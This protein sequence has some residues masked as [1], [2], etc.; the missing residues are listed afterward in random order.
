MRLQ[1]DTLK[2]LTEAKKR[3]P[4]SLALTDS[5]GSWTYRELDSYAR[6]CAVW[7]RRKGVEPGDRVV[8]TA[9]NTRVVVALI[10]GCAAAGATAVPL[11]P[12]MKDFHREHVVVDAQP[13]LVIEDTAPL[14]VQFEELLGLT[15]AS[16]LPGPGTEPALLLYTS[17]S[18]GMPKA[19]VCPHSS[20]DFASRAVHRELRYQQDDV[21]LCRIPLSFDYGLYQIYL[22]ALSGAKLVLSQ[23]GDEARI[24]ADIKKHGVTVV[25]LVPSLANVLTRLAR[26]G[27]ENSL[28]RCFTNTG[29]RLPRGVVEDLRSFF[30]GAEVRLMFG[31]TEC[32]RITIMEADGDLE[33]PDSVGRPL[34]GTEVEIVDFEG[35]PLPSG[36]VGEI[37]VRGPHVM[38]GYW[39]NAEST[40]EV[41]RGDPSGRTTLHTGDYGHMD[42]EG[43]VYFLGRRDNIFKRQ[44]NRV[45]TT[46]IETA[47]LAVPGVTQAITL[48]PQDGG[49][50]KLWFT[51]DTTP[52]KLL[53]GM[54]DRLEKTKVPDTA[55]RVSSFPLN[56][57]GKIDRLKVAAMETAPATDTAGLTA[58]FGSPLYIYDLDTLD[59]ALAS[60]RKTVPS[61]STVYYSLKANPHPEIVRVFREGGARAEI[62]SSG[63]LLSA[64]EAGFTGAEC[65]Y[66]GPG[67]TP[68]EIE[69][70]LVHGVRLFSV[71]S[72][73][74]YA[75]IA[76]CADAR[77]VT[78][79][80][81][82]RVNV[83]ASDSRASLR[84]TGTSTQFGVDE[85]QLFDA[86]EKFSR[87]LGA[88]V[89]G[90]HFFSLSN[91]QDEESLMTAMRASAEA[92]RRLRDEGGF[93]MEVVDLGGG[94]AAPYARPGELPAYTS[95]RSEL[96][97]VLDECLP[98]WRTGEVE[99]AFESG[100]YLSGSCGRLL[101]RVLDLKDS[102]GSSFVVTDSGIN[103]L[104]GLAGL[105]RTLPVVVV[106]DDPAPEERT[107]TLVGPLCTPA[108]VLARRARLGEVARGDVLEVLNV[109]A[110]G[111]S[112]SL[113]GFLSRP[114]P[115]EVA[116]RRGEIVS[117]DRV[118]LTRTSLLNTDD[119]ELK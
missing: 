111:L 58:R 108:D 64:I 113:L 80:C 46:E 25:P 47:A 8:F 62:S 88:K 34:P 118:L 4:H 99:I 52:R 26:R 77:G 39:N 84:M 43:Y 36:S 89:V 93:P 45:S 72:A 35:H 94:F 28:V 56:S 14:L 73:S 96:E 76:E 9:D 44:G 101:M 41:F 16:Q 23:I 117:A 85:Q 104:G 71:E 60:L 20:I 107:G 59:T 83:S 82:I 68:E 86:P 49:E 5:S 21:V 65:L 48:P 12:K 6:A 116:L 112:A 70:A 115:V 69:L 92:A 97:P 78:A 91:A 55:Q 87:R 18:T 109:G 2:I 95:F 75:R 51:G 102:K 50:L 79:S 32:K 63:E 66:T 106:P 15:E 40:R 37:T 17:G 42:E 19:V 74:D 103:H 30:P 114:T 1:G 54:R 61:P 57:N 98:G 67:K 90:A 53:T 31:T 119:E 11:N 38:A 7:M 13:K 3:Y 24:L 100:R 81:L 105:G 27:V 33:R 10:L 29:E 110:Y 22:C